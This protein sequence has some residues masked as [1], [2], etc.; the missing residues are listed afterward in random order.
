MTKQSSPYSLPSDAYDKYFTPPQEEGETKEP[1]GAEIKELYH[2]P[3][4]VGGTITET[5]DIT[6]SPTVRPKCMKYF[7]ET[8]E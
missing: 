2:Q 5:Q 6:I 1:T 8:K 3:F 7:V 4:T